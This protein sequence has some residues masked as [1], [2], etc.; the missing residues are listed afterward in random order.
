MI[1]VLLKSL[2]NI[3]CAFLIIICGRE[4]LETSNMLYCIL[5]WF[6]VYFMLELH[7]RLINYLEENL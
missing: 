2:C 1:D 6:G 7:V 3:T 5:W 4:A